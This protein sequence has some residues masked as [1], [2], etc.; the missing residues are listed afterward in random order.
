MKG[1]ARA[2]AILLSAWRP[3]TK[4]ARTGNG[5]STI[6]RSPGIRSDRAGSSTISISII[7]RNCI[8]CCGWSTS[9][10]TVAKSVLEVGCGAA[11]DLARFARGGAVVDRRR[12]SPIRRS[13]SRRPISRSRGCTESFASPTE[14][15]C[16]LPTMRSI[17]STRTASCS[18]LPNPQRLVDECRRVL[19]PG[20]QAIFQVYNRVSWLNALSKLMKV[21]LEHDDAPVL[22]KFS[23]GEFRRLAVR[24]FATCGSCPSAFPSSR[25]CTAAGRARS[26]TASSSEPSTCCRGRSSGG[27][28]GICWRFVANDHIR[29]GARL[30]QRLPLR[31]ERATSRASVWTR[32]RARSATG[33]PA[34]APTV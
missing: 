10:G 22:L 26:T 31:A 6:S 2:P 25:G 18:T 15:S 27:S 30:R 19:K 33:T 29:Q 1:S 21:G 7:S 4:C 5:T 20:G 12:S 9:T 34:S 11:V 14:S 16:R 23:I 8:T 24:V 28:A 13:S 17:S 3:S 32:S